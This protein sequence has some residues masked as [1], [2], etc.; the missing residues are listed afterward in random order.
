MFNQSA[1][2][3]CAFLGVIEGD[4][5]VFKVEIA[6]NK[7]IIDLKEIIRK[8]GEKR[9]LANVDTKDIILLKVT[10]TQSLA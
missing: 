7:R 5:E 3:I 8:K 1:D 9:V 10:T 6:A 2:S 4:D